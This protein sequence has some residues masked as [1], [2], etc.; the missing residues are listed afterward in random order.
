[1]YFY[2]PNT[3]LDPDI[4]HNAKSAAKS[5]FPKYL[6]FSRTSGEIMPKTFMES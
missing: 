1:M 3:F 6:Y 2:I 5:K 4:A